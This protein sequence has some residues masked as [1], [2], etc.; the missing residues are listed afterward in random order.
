M[1]FDP[2]KLKFGVY[3]YENFKS[4]RYYEEYKLKM[5]EL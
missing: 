3:E 5:C 1:P 4:Y 2:N